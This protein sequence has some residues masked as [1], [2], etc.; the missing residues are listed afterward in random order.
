MSAGSAKPFGCSALTTRRRVLAGLSA[1]LSAAL[2]VACAGANRQIPALSGEVTPVPAAPGAPGTAP[3]PARIEVW[4]PFA[5]GTMLGDTLLRL[6]ERFRSEHPATTPNLTAVPGNQEFL[7][8]LETAFAGGQPPHAFALDI[9]WPARFVAR[10]LLQPLDAW[11]SRSGRTGTGTQLDRTDFVPAA[12]D[13]CTIGGTVYAL[14][15]MLSVLLLYWNAHHFAQAGLDPEHPPETWDD[16]LRLSGALTLPDPAAPSGVRRWGFQIPGPAGWNI[17]AWQCFLWQRGGELLSADGRHSRF[18]EQPGIDALD[19]WIELAQRR[20]TATLEPGLAPFERGH[21]AMIIQTLTPIGSMARTAPD[22]A[23]RSAV[24]PR[25]VQAATNT[26]GW[27]WGLAAGNGLRP[28]DLD[29]AAEWIRWFSAPEQLGTWNAE[30]GFIPPRYSAQATASWRAASAG[31]L[32]RAALA[33]LPIA[34]TRPKF[35]AY[36]EWSAPLGTA[37]ER[38]VRGELSARDA[39][40]SASQEA[41]AV[42]A[43]AAV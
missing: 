30:T 12:L 39:L 33:S 3:L 20:R 5:P 8:K 32:W 19:F 37:I 27:L 34:R 23:L 7:Q 10:R 35:A 29:G 17:W 13:A 15:M 40:E 18:A 24:L 11:F 43:R 41:D 31:P 21:V 36:L 2:A 42:L 22:V 9:I 4:Q 28:I 16:L 1:S 26:G 25:D 6:A 38:A 14:P